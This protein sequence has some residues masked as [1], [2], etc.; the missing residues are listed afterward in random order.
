ME[1][2]VNRTHY[3]KKE[4]KEDEIKVKRPK[5]GRRRGIEVDSEDEYIKRVLRV[6]RFEKFNWWK[7]SIGSLSLGLDTREPTEAEMEMG[8]SLTIYF[9]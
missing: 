5:R 1:I 9:R 8:P 2:H 6:S 3:R 4:M 7:D